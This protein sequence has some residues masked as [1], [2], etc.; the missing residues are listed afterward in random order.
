MKNTSFNSRVIG[1]KLKQTD[2]QSRKNHY[3]DW[4]IAYLWFCWLKSFFACT[5]TAESCSTFDPLILLVSTFVLFHQVLFIIKR[6]WPSDLLPLFS[7]LY[8][9]TNLDSYSLPPFEEGLFIW[10]GNDEKTGNKFHEVMTSIRTS[11]YFYLS[12]SSLLC[13]RG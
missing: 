1:R 10:C 3:T 13:W 2:I 7:T 8:S 9:K 12:W 5:F 6:W 4:V 11:I